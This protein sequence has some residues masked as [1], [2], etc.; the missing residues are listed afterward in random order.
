MDRRNGYYFAE[1]KCYLTSDEDRTVMQNLL[2]INNWG[3][4]AINGGGGGEIK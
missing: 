3:G 4:G 2:K 1:G